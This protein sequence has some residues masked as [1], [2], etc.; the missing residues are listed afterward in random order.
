[1]LEEEYPTSIELINMFSIM[2][3]GTNQNKLYILEFVRNKS[4][5]F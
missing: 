4:N 2:I 3:I 1:M 5:G